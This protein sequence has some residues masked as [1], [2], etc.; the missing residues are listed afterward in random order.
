LINPDQLNHLP[1]KKQRELARVVK[2]IFDEFED[3]QKTKLSD[4]ARSGRILKLIL[5]GSYS[6]GDWVE[7][8]SSGYRSCAA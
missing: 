2:I 3:A 8:R 1:A 4:K 6:R 7:D 5:F